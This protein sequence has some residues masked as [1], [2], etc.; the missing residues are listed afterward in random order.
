M[1]RIPHDDRLIVKQHFLH[2]IV[3]GRR[4]AQ[5]AADKYIDVAL[6]ER[7]QQVAVGRLDHSH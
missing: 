5:R 1:L 7:V 6:P 4:I 3:G 2:D